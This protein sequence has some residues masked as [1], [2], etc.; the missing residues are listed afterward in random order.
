MLIASLVQTVEQQSA[1][2]T[3]VIVSIFILGGVYWPLSLVPDFMQNI[4][5]FIPQT[6]AMKGYT[7]LIINE[8]SIS[9]IALPIVVLLRFAA[10]F[11][12]VGVGRVRYE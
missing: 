8:A 6:W 1:I 3:L 11:L 7:E 5:Q 9:D 4:A 12:A 10:V 2:G